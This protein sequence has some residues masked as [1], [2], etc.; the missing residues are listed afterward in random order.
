MAARDFY[1]TLGVGKNASK[2]EIKR[3]Y[4]R[5]AHEH[6]P[7]KGGGEAAKFK[8]I[9][10]AYE[11]LS[12]DVRRAQYDRYGQ[13]FEQA[14]SQGGPGGFG[15]FGGFEDFSEFMRGFGDNFSRGPYGGMNFDFGDAFSDIFGGGRTKRSE[16][17]VDLEMQMTLDFLE[18]VFGAEKIVSL[19]RRDICP[20]C[21]GSGTAE[22]SKVST[23]PK[24]HGQG[25]ITT[26][27]Q[28][29]L[30][31]IQNIEVC[32]RCEGTGKVPDKACADCRGRGS[33]KMHKEVKISV[34]AGIQDG[35]RL[36]LTGEG[37]VGYRGSKRGDLY[38][39]VRVRPHKEWERHGH[40]IV[41]EVPVSFFQAALG[42][43]AEI[44]TVDGKVDL[45]IPAGTQSGKMLRLRGKGV[46]YGSGRGDHITIIRVI[47]PTKLTK[48]EKEIL[49][50]LAEE[51]G[52]SVNI[53]GD[54][55]GRIKDNF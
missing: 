1:E 53:D 40:D 52:E 2:D 28:T 15:G 7:D 41:A 13:T 4:R 19:E 37:E 21:R 14:R 48:K 47:T 49:R 46:P 43:K 20:T 38:V 8:E 26:R 18:S 12:D 42:G 34:P 6:H 45:K 54:L 51:R 30:G 36:R 39:V 11:V 16:Q 31:M 22:G 5:L 50:K 17:G 55:W 35:Q 23:C 10:Q 33:R 9:N 32:D 44:N 25:Q 27:R 24:C 29:M 3:A